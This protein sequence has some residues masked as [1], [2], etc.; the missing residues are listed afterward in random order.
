L[1]SFKPIRLVYSKHQ[2]I[3]TSVAAANANMKK[4]ILL[5]YLNMIRLYLNH[6][7]NNLM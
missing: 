1:N 6:Q 3:A 7:F 2:T 4:E 5:S